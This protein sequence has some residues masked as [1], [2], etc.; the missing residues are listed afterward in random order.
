L[1]N[2]LEIQIKKDYHRFTVWSE[3]Q[4]ASEIGERWVLPHPPLCSSRKKW[5]LSQET[6]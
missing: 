6:I 2:A 1:I 5:P 3:A 4:A